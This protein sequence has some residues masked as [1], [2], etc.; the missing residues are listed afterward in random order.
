M[1]RNNAVVA[2][3]HYG[4]PFMSWIGVSATA[5]CDSPVKSMAYKVKRKPCCVSKLGLSFIPD[6]LAHEKIHASP[7]IGPCDPDQRHD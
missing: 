2:A 5:G 4:A 6:R 3:A 1:R 7:D